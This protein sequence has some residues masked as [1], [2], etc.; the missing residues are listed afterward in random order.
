MNPVIKGGCPVLNSIIYSDNSNMQ[1]KMNV[2]NAVD[3]LIL[4]LEFI[5]KSGIRTGEFNEEV[6]SHNAA[7]FIFTA[8]EGGVAVTRN[9]EDGRYMKIIIDQLIDYVKKEIVK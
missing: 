7:V 4:V 6:N 3:E 1:F 5:I 2:R 9:Y 8:I